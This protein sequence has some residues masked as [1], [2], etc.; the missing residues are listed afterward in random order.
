[1]PK[2]QGTVGSIEQKQ[3]QTGKTYFK[4]NVNGTWYSAWTNPGVSVGD[5]IEFDVIQKGEYKNMANPVKI[6]AGATSPV[7]RGAVQTG[8]PNGSF[9][10]DR[11]ARIVRQNATSSAV[12]L[13]AASKLAGKGDVEIILATVREV[14]RKVFEMNF[15]GYDAD[16]SKPPTAKQ[17]SPIEQTVS[18]AKAAAGFFDE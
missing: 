9:D 11:E 18:D 7:A 14:A 2:T 3:T 17:A 13:V 4:V 8:R 15:Y 6:A 10:P 12:A 1:M 16:T 5:E